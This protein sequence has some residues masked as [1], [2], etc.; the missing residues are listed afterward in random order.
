MA[1]ENTVELIRDKIDILDIVKDYV[2]SLK[3][4]GRTYKGCCPFH[5]EKTP[6]FTVSPDKGLFY[7][8]G[9]Q[10]GGD[11]FAFLM[12]AES[13][14]F[15]EAAKKLA[16]RAG[17]E[18]EQ[19]ESLTDEDKR[20]LRAREAMTFAKDFYHKTLL[21]S[22]GNDIRAYLKSRNL[23]KETTLKFELGATP[24]SQNGLIQEAIKAGFDMPLLKSLGL[25]NQYGSDYFRARMMF[26]IIN[27]RGEC[28]AFGG[29]ITGAGEP[30]YLNSPESI[31]FSKSRVLYGLN[32]AG[33]AIRK[34]EFVLL[35]EGYM[36]VISCMQAGVE[37]CVAPLGTAFG[38]EHAKLLKRYTD[39]AIVLF[40]PDPAGIKASLRTALILIE[41]GLFV[42]VA[43]LGDEGL[44]P[45]EYIFKYGKEQFDNVVGE[46]VDIITFRSDVLVQGSPAKLN[47]QEK[48]K[49]A[50]ELMEIIS[51]QPDA[52]IKAEWI[53]TAADKLDIDETILLR[54]AAPARQGP[55]RPAA[56]TAKQVSKTPQEE[57]DLLAWT[58]LFP[59]ECGLSKNLTLEYFEDNSIFKA[60]QTV[61][62]IYA[63]FPSGEG[64]AQKVC[65]AHPD[66]Q[67][68][69]IA[70][71][72]RELP[73]DF[74]AARDINNTIK[75]IERKYTA[76]KL[77]ALKQKIK[78]LGTG[79]VPEELLR[80]Q[81]E[82]QKKLKI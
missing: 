9:C 27:P 49:I 1:K 26:P 60:L 21:S 82:L 67:S 53:K 62:K 78:T 18:W 20:R 10:T 7:C 31:L 64:L 52:V 63:D 68:R 58:I 70:M 29:R 19:K 77:T 81:I 72:V 73:K 54:G 75:K 61:Q 17:V 12:K 40:D 39:T 46:A 79:N 69:I 24:P 34:Q 41:E 51:K 3:R 47:A 76:R 45:D 66:M 38:P 48:S 23:T 80:L 44:D 37:N 11:V 28:I 43:S 56:Q 8:F 74:I 4:A 25:A 36:D 71:S 50:A 55:A 5:S 6:S 59:S 35:L 22:Q 14:S 13:L 32:F 33:P 42:K 57:E 65:E 15:N 30:K 16:D 2:P